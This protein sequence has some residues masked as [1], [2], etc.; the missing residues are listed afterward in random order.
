MVIA[1]FLGL[2][3]LAV[4]VTGAGLD[5][6][7]LVACAVVVLVGIPGT[8]IELKVRARRAGRAGAVGRAGDS[9]D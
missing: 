3:V 5:E 2:I 8:V 6:A 1:G 4:V 9:L 7:P